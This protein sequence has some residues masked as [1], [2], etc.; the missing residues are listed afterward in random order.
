MAW[1]VKL[2][3]LAALKPAGR[4]AIERE[5]PSAPPASI[6]P[7]PK[8]SASNCAWNGRARRILRPTLTRPCLDAVRGGRIGPSDQGPR[9][10]SRFAGTRGTCNSRFWP[11]PPR[12]SWCRS[13]SSRF[14]SSWPSTGGIRGPEPAAT[15]SRDGRPCRRWAFRPMRRPRCWSRSSANTSSGG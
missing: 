2:L 9:V 13:R 1:I 12:P 7:G 11:P 14:R 15:T 8:R 5:P 4:C 3:T 10:T 6:P